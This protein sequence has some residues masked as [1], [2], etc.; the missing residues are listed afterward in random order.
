MTPVNRDE[1]RKDLADHAV[2]VGS[3]ARR[4]PLDVQ[5]RRTR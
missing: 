3:V 4:P 2:L 1:R 5:D